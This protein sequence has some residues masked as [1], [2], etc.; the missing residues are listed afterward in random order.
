VASPGNQNRGDRG[1][2]WLALVRTLIIQIVVL[3]AL[4]AAISHYLD[5]SSDANWAEFI[6]AGQTSGLAPSHPRS[7]PVQPAKGQ[8]PCRRGD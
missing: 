6:A 7:Q 2:T 3:L 4:A 1:S 5:W 8:A